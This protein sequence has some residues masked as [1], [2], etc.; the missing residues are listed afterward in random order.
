M[1][2]NDVSNMI[3]QL[4][5]RTLIDIHDFDDKSKKILIEYPKYIR[6]CENIKDVFIK[7]TIVEKSNIKEDIDNVFNN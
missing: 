2:G 1:L 5:S 7:R 3:N 4:L 6:R